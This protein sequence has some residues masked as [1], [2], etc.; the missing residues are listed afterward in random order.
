MAVL[1]GL[2]ITSEETMGCPIKADMDVVKIGVN[3]EGMDVMIGRNAWEADGIIV[4]CRIKPPHLLRGPY[5]SGI[6]KMMTIGL[7]KQAGAECATRPGFK[8]MAKYAHVPEG[9]SCSRPTFCS[10]WP[11]WR[12]PSTRPLRLSP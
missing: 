3:E 5:E 7:G 12:T 11:F 9:P 6:M 4:S 8:Y 10:R 2:G 1:S